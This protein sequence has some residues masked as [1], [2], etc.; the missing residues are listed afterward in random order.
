MDFLFL[1]QLFLY[2]YQKKKM[3]NNFSISVSFVETYTG[4]FRFGLSGME[5]DD[6]IYG[7]GNAYT[8][9][10]RELDTRLGGR[11]W[12]LDTK[13]KAGESPYVGFGDNPIVYCDPFGKDTLPSSSSGLPLKNLKPVSIV[14]DRP[15]P[16]P[17]ES[18]VP[19]S[20]QNAILGDT[21]SFAKNNGESLD[22][23]GDLGSGLKETAKIVKNS[24]VAAVVGYAGDGLNF[25]GYGGDILNFEANRED[26]V[27]GEISG[28]RFAYKTTGT[29]LSVGTDLAVSYGLLESIGIGAGIGS[30]GFDPAGALLGGAVGGLFWLGEKAYD[31]LPKKSSKEYSKESQE[32]EKIITSNHFIL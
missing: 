28:K 6:E 24:H 14:A 9:E 1:I 10:F 22:L 32:F 13:T 16:P 18:E 8:T 25:I 15:K 19:Q 26:Y 3:K 20:A 7:T 12:S 31:H 23:I 17:T 21:V 27:S 2:F 30:T 5:K 29:V 4:R 11:C